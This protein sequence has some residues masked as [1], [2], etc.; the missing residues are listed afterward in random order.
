MEED[1]IARE[2]YRR[3]QNGLMERQQREAWAEAEK[4]QKKQKKKE[5]GCEVM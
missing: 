4:L 5:G 1:T 3:R 2:I